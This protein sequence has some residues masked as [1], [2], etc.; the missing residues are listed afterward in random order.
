[1]LHL[2]LESSIFYKTF[3]NQLSYIDN[4]IY[5]LC[6]NVVEIYNETEHL[7]LNFIKRK[8]SN[9]LGKVSNRLFML[10]K[11]R[12]LL[13][14]FKFDIIETIYFLYIFLLL[15]IHKKTKVVFMQH[16]IFF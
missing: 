6:Q 7:I 13:K 2:L 12:K 16:G 3:A 5:I 9:A 1:M 11:I 15:L 8:Y 14:K 10:N 4:N